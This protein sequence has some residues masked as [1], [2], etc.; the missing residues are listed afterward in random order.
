MRVHSIRIWG[1]TCVIVRWVRRLQLRVAHCA[2]T[3]RRC[4]IQIT[5]PGLVS[6]A[7]NCRQLLIE[8]MFVD[9]I[10]LLS[11]LTVGVKTLWSLVVFADYAGI[12]SYPSLLD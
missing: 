7:L 4:Q 3:E 11:D 8:T 5:G 10:K 12:R 6:H 1:N 9:F 2:K